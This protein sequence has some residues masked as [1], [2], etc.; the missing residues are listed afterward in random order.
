[1]SDRSHDEGKDRAKAP[2]GDIATSRARVRASL[3]AGR[4]A[5]A[6]RAVLTFLRDNPPSLGV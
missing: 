4:P 5:R 2:G 6:I 1:M 3:I